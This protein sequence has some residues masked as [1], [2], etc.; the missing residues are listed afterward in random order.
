MASRTAPPIFT[1]WLAIV[2]CRSWQVAY[3]EVRV[4]F[5]IAPLQV[6]P[7]QTQQLDS[8]HS[9]T[10]KLMHAWQPPHCFAKELTSGRLPVNDGSLDVHELREGYNE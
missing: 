5:T 6:H 1:D 7:N 3:I 4:S 2:E 9:A 8:H 10:G